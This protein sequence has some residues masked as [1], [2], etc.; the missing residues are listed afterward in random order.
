MQNILARIDTNLALICLIPVL[1][2]MANPDWL[3]SGSGGYSDSYYYYS[4]WY[5]YFE[6]PHVL[7]QSY[8]ASRLVWILKGYVLHKLFNP[9]TA[10]YVLHLTTLYACII[11]FYFTLKKVANPFTATVATILFLTFTHFHAIPGYEWG[12]HAHE[13]AMNLL[14]CI[15]CLTVAAD[16]KKWKKYLFL[17]GAAF[18]A[19]CHMP[20]IASYFP[21]VLAWYWFFN[22]KGNKNPLFASCVWFLLGG[23]IVTFLFGIIHYSVTGNFFFFMPQIE[24]VLNLT[25]QYI[26][27]YSAGGESEHRDIYDSVWHAGAFKSGHYLKLIDTFRNLKEIHMAIAFAFLVF[28]TLIV[29]ILK[30]LKERFLD[31]STPN[32]KKRNS[33]VA[34]F[35]LLQFLITLLPHLYLTI[36][37]TPAL[38]HS[39]MVINFYPSMFFAFAGIILL[40]TRKPIKRKTELSII[41]GVICTA[42]LMFHPE[43]VTFTKLT[44]NISFPIFFGI[45]LIVGLLL[46]SPIVALK[47]KNLVGLT[48]IVLIFTGVNIGSAERGEVYGVLQP[49]KGLHKRTMFAAI[50][51]MMEIEKYDHKFSTRLWYDWSD[52]MK[53][54]AN[55]EC[56][57]YIHTPINMSR[58]FDT[59][60]GMRWGSYSHQ[61]N[62]YT[63]KKS[64]EYLQYRDS[65]RLKGRLKPQVVNQRGVK[66][67]LDENR[68]AILSSKKDK[69][70]TALETLRRK[71][72]GYKMIHEKKIVRGDISYFIKIIETFD[73]EK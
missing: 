6:D 60:S 32:M 54:S 26:D 34:I 37:G 1:L 67:I 21:M 2:Y 28:I 55:P 11:A 35:L 16:S 31:Q 69:I 10:Y 52:E 25:S 39:Y 43:I 51:G 18:A 14:L 70:S 53:E 71:D 62:E 57:F 23:V 68:I 4:Y 24:Q 38:T 17:G 12:Y 41:V 56:K 5:H 22:R 8:K 9:Y 27:V 42:V 59:I 3:F 46:V 19:G 66:V 20:F 73:A 48:C 47:Q 33:S 29:G 36:K 61:V 72:V 44:K 30:R 65:E 45:L 64:F 58:L 7:N 63:S 15:L 40:W 13:G 49:C 50:D